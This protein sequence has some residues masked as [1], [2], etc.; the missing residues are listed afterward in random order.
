MGI[1]FSDRPMTQKKSGA[2]KE[3]Q[4]TLRGDRRVAEN[5]ILEVRALAQR[6]GLDIAEVA[7]IPQPKIGPK[8]TKKAIK[9]RRKPRS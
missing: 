1:A 8:T 3:L 5:L 4:V 9:Q 6:C 2:P 7:V